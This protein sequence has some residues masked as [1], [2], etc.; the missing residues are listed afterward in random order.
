MPLI[1]QRFTPELIRG[2]R[3]LKTNKEA[4]LPETVLLYPQRKFPD[5]NI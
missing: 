4:G 5:V 2:V 1:A 3:I